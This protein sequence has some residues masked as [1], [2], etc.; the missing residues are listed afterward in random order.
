MRIIP[1]D[2]PSFYPYADS[3]NKAYWRNHTIEITDLEFD[4]IGDA[5]V[6]EFIENGFYP[7]PS[8]F[9]K[10]L[11]ELKRSQWNK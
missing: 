4:M 10:K 1:D 6:S 8:A 11:L 9:I 7:Q 3:P 2:T 5:L